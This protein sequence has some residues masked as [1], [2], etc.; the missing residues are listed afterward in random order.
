MPKPPPAHA[1]DHATLPPSRRGGVLVERKVWFPAP[2]VVALRQ[3]LHGDGLRVIV[4][5]RAS[6]LAQV[7]VQSGSLGFP[8]AGGLVPAPRRFV[9]SVPPRSIL[10][11]RFDDAVLHSDGLGAARALGRSGKPALLEWR[12]GDESPDPATLSE[13][14]MAAQPLL[15]ELDADAAVPVAVATAR[16][17]L[18]QR[19]GDLAPVAAVARELAMASETLSRGFVRAYGLSPKQYCTRA[20]LFD[21]AIELFTGA[22]I[23]HA[24]L[25][26]GWNDLSRFYAQFQKLLG[27]TPGLYAACRRAVR[28]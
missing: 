2:G 4:T 14:A 25:D 18:H 23:V 26:A 3:R 13:A 19:L 20:R 21:A 24:A 9:L 16:A 6:L 11:I 27:A 5:H 17:R 1:A 10:P 28:S 7:E 8:L 12:T 22:S 15:C